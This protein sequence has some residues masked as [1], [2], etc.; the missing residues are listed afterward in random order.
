MGYLTA[1]ARVL[2]CASLQRRLT[3]ISH[4]HKTAGYDDTPTR[5]GLVRRALEGIRRV[6]GTAPNRKAPCGART[7]GPW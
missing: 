7:S 3:S 1:Y 4:A 2:S 6:H 5:H